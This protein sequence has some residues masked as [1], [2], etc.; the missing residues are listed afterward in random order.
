MPII[1]LLEFYKTRLAS[2]IEMIASDISVDA[3]FSITVCIL[4]LKNS[5]I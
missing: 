3:T 5:S 2:L 4:R 1:V